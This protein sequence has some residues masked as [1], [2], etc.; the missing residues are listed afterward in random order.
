MRPAALPSLLLVLLGTAAHSQ[1]SLLPQVG[2]EQSRTSIGYNGQPSFSPLGGQGAPRAALRADYRLKSGHGAFAS[3]GTSPAVVAFTFADPAG[4]LT[5]YRA[6]ASHLQWRLEGGYQYSTKPLYFKKSGTGSLAAAGDAVTPSS[7]KKTCGSY[8]YRSKCGSGSKT[9]MAMKKKDTRWNMRLQPSVGAAFIPGVKSDLVTGNGTYRYNAGNW[10]TALVAGSGFEFGKGLQRKFTVSF[11]FL[12]GLGN[13]GTQTLVTER[14]AKTT[15]TRFDSKV[16]GW[17]MTLG[18]PFTLSK[19]KALVQQP[20]VEQ[21]NTE[22][23]TEY[24]SKCGQRYQIEYRTRCTRKVV[25]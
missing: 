8:T 6:A 14:N 5:S 2:F 11:Y 17:N 19:K 9:T 13:L 4:A 24:K 22:Q 7:G 10:N 25:I 23:K 12:K 20:K 21:K 15:E 1:L 18:L 16:S 3:V